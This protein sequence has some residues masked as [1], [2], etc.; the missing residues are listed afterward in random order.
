MNRETRK[1]KIRYPH[2][3]WQ[4]HN[5][6]EIPYNL[7]TEAWMADERWSLRYP[8]GW[9]T[10]KNMPNPMSKIITCYTTHRTSFRKWSTVRKKR[11]EKNETLFDKWIKSNLTLLLLESPSWNTRWQEWDIPFSRDIS[12]FLFSFLEHFLQRLWNRS[13]LYQVK[14]T[15]RS[16]HW[17]TTL[18]YCRPRTCCCLIQSCDH[19]Y[20]AALGTRAPNKEI[21]YRSSHSYRS[22][23]GV[24][25]YIATRWL[26]GRRYLNIAYMTQTPWRTKIE[27]KPLL[28][29][30]C[31]IKCNTKVDFR[32]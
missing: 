16:F 26:V 18:G 3:R 27:A 29:I 20:N 12:G 8:P 31:I 2:L 7:R 21:K 15:S 30:L 10:F 24:S 17:R 4:I 25:M 5:H 32:N 14:Q 19:T 11:S 6:G 13:Q 28:T 23:K 22:R 1:V 9:K